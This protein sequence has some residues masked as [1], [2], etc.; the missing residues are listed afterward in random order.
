MIHPFKWRAAFRA[1]A[2]R[3]RPMTRA[4][5]KA[6]AKAAKKAASHK[7]L[8]AAPWL[9]LGVLLALWPRPA[10]GDHAGVAAALETGRGRQARAPQQIPATG[11]RDVIW[12]TLR[13]FM[14]DQIQTVAGSVAFSGIMALFPAMAAFVSLY[15]MFSDVGAARDHLALLAGFIPAD[16]LTFIGEQM[17]RIAQQKEASLSLTFIIS[18]VLSL[19]SANA[20][21]K[22]LFAGLNI[23]YDETEKR[24]FI[25]KNLITLS[26]TIGAVL[27][28]VVASVGVI[29]LPIVL[30]FFWL[31]AKSAFIVGLRWP[32]MALVTMLALSI[33]YRYGPSREKAQWRWVTWGGALAALL[34]L[35]G[36][37]LFSF[38]LAHFG[39][40]NATYGSLGAIFGLF[41]WIWLS[42]VIVLLGAEL[43]SEIEHQTAV[44]STTGAPMP[45]G[46]RGATMADSLGKAKRGGVEAYLPAFVTRWV[47]GGP[48]PAPTAKEPAGKALRESS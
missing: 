5:Q 37:L 17:V 20:A 48:Q 19:W 1:V 39:H 41:T 3:D 7:S 16:A 9:A 33:V 44:D 35:G 30:Q 8:S 22:A 34:W 21:M 29:V 11:W 24:S 4:E 42:C 14:D 18:L 40:Y 12:R 25:Q 31:D 23:A 10:H 32:I 43:N 26:F 38:Y 45:M 36:S 46:L 28:M 15:G 6:H 27:F 13:E 47:K 2:R